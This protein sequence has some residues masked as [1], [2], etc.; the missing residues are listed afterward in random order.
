M[1]KN[2]ILIFLLLSSFSLPG[3][4]QSKI[5]EQTKDQD[6]MDFIEKF[7]N[8]DIPL[9]SIDSFKTL[10]TKMVLDTRES[11][12]F[13]VSH[14]KNARNVGFIWFDMRDLYDIP[15]SKTLVVY[16]AIGRRGEKIAEKLIKA[17][18]QHVFCLKGSLFR[19][20]NTGNPVYTSDGIQTTEV[21]IYEKELSKWLFKGT[22]VH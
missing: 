21:H 19:W 17:G 18:Y 7:H 13:E 22:R 4:S 1:L 5:V 20:V 3:Y 9:M 2:V 16:S 14:L 8:P 12:E 10:K 11:E 6:Y 15:K